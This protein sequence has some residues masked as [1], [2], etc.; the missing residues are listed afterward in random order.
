MNGLIGLTAF[1]SKMQIPFVVSDFVWC[2]QVNN[3]EKQKKR[4][5]S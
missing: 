1:L 3:C 4:K 2:E 5:T